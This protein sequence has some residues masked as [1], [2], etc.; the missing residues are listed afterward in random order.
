MNAIA[1]ATRVVPVLVAVA[2]LALTGCSKDSKPLESKE[3]GRI[4]LD[5]AFYQ[6]QLSRVLNPK[7]V[8]DGYYLEG[9]SE[10]QAGESYFG[11]F[12]RVDNEETKHRVTPIGVDKMRIVNASGN[13]FEPIP[14]K[15]SGWGYSQAPL[16][17]GA[18][19]P[20]PDSPADIG[21]IRGALIL[22]RIP[23]SDLDARPL[24]LEIESEHG[25][26]GKILIDV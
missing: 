24:E 16:G 13:E 17:K 21:P 7:D 23:Q 26:P 22:F 3:G 12:M 15:S 5:G 2:A 6:V 20:I 25:K 4:Y 10:P 9:Q 8:E 1:R 18:H 11:V 14:V 19:M